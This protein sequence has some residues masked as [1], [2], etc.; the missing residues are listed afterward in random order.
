MLLCEICS[1]SLWFFSIS[2]TLSGYDSYCASYNAFVHTQTTA[3]NYAHTH[4]WIDTS[5]LTHPVQHR[6]HQKMVIME[7]HTRLLTI[8]KIKHNNNVLQMTPCKSRSVIQQL[9]SFDG[10]QTNL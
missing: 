9:S 2:V 5:K 6:M 4:T 10:S 1:F 7:A 8:L 3:Y